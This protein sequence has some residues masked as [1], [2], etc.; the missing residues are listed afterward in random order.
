MS[1][2]MSPGHI[3]VQ[4]VGRIVSGFNQVGKLKS[5]HITARVC[6]CVCVCVCVYVLAQSIGDEAKAV[7]C[8]CDQITGE[9][10][11]SDGMF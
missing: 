10:V 9:T 8:M 11:Y 3:L 6:V 5:K 2:V 4:T 1:L 7:M